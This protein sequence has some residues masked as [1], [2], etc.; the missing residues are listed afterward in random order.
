MN[1]VTTIEMS[2]IWGISARRIALLC[3]QGRIAG[4]VKKGK[5]WLIPEDAEKPADKRKNDSIEL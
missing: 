2:E 1:Y 4:V 5:T 3:E